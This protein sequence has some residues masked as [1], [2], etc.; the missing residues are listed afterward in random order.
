M[1]ALSAVGVAPTRTVKAGY[2][3][4]NGMAATVLVSA[5]RVKNVSQAVAGI[6]ETEVCV[7]S[8]ANHKI[9]VA[10]R[11]GIFAMAITPVI[12]ESRAL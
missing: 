1:V 10:Q 4:T 11:R 6:S 12:P 7:Y 9:N 3:L 8:I 2:V 5:R